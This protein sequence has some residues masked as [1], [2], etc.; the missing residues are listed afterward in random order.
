VGT[1]YP[2]RG[3]IAHYIALLYEYLKKKHDVSVV[4]FKLQYPKIFFPGKSQDEKGGNT[5]KIETKQL[6]NSVNPFNWIL[7]AYYLIKLNPDVMIFKY[8]MPFF[9]P[10]Y[11]IISMIV[12][13]FRKVKIIYIC[14]NLIPH[15]RRF[16]DI[17]L[18]KFAFRFVDGGIVQSSAVE[19]DF[20][21]LFPKKKFVNV[22]HPIYTIFGE[23]YSKKES[24]SLI[25]V[26]D[27][28]IILFFGY[29]RSYK[30]L[31][32]LLSAMPFVL[33]KIK[34]RLMIV[35]EFYGDYEKYLDK[36][37][38]LKLENAITIVSDYVPNEDV[39]KYFSA[40]DIVVLPYISATQSGIVQIAYNFDKPVIATDVGGLSEVI[41]N[42][43]T[44]YIVKSQNPKL[45]AD[46]IIRFYEENK[47]NEFV[48][49]VIEEKK[50]YSWDYMVEGV[51][52]LIR[53][54]SIED[55]K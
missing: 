44:G 54:I 49:N 6:I 9:A 34:L 4:T 19:K 16:G 25:N 30:G 42:N 28:K 40:S 47:E 52:K 20:I 7:S 14:D 3:G 43:K 8:W 10:C 38:L 15:E 48:A 18:T 41:I 32:V 27:E 5:A 53:N 50:K 39:G 36:I 46:A 33:D 2:L 13:I 24:R 55:K 45:L 1:A 31:N 23:S 22:P 21:S 51:E 11:A 29:V 17:F 26:N 37:K 35:G 12:K